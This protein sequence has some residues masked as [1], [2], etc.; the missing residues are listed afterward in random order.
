M[1]KI[2]A[3]IIVLLAFQQC[4]SDKTELLTSNY[5]DP[6]YYLCHYTSTPLS[7]DGVMN[8]AVWDSVPWTDE[9]V[10]IFMENKLPPVYK[11]RV[12][13]LWDDTYCYFAAV[14]E[15]PDMMAKFTKRDTVI[16][17]EN[18]FEIFIDPNGDNHEYY[19]F[20][21]NALGTVWD[22]ILPKAYRD[23]GVPDNSWNIDGL[24]SGIKINGTLNDPSDRDSGWITEIAIPWAA[25]KDYAHM[26]LPPNESDQWRINFLR[27][28]YLPKIVNGK[29]EK[30]ETKPT[31]N[32]V[33]TPHHSSN[34]HD[35][36]SFGIVQFTKKGF[37]AA[38]VNIDASL[39]A[40][41]ILMQIYNAQKKYFKKNNKWASSLKELGVSVNQDSTVKVA[42]TFEMS[43]EGFV[44]S[45]ELSD[46]DKKT[47]WHTNE[48][49]KLWK[50]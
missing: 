20:E 42:E 21:M 37:G 4:K 27:V 35:P 8:E 43:K 10:D 1:R 23:Q 45:V 50:E 5:I 31:N 15:E 18:D 32:L 2:A 34:M 47:I 13:M 33:W 38:E 49:S 11:T 14:M 3:I 41:G 12:K 48:F 25:F 17:L 29:Y 6:K 19:E 16:C 36:E 44:A 30:D 28:E 22:L 26:S 40:R 7:V 9:F 39:P 46:G 24:V